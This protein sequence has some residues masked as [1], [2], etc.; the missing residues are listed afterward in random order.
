MSFPS[1]QVIE[2]QSRG[3]RIRNTRRFYVLNPSVLAY[4]FEWLDTTNDQ[5]EPRTLRLRVPNS[6]TSCWLRG[7]PPF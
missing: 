5:A 3:V 7:V 4:D 1:R 2:F 6:R